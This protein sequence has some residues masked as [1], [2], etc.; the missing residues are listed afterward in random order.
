MATPI[1]Q[2]EADPSAPRPVLLAPHPQKKVTDAQWEVIKSLYCAGVSSGD[3][4]KDY[5]ITSSTIRK[6]ATVEKWPTPQRIS[7]AIKTG[8]RNTDDPAAAIADLW[9]SRKQ[10]GRESVYQGSKKALERFFAMAPVPQSFQEA[11][12]AHKMME[13]AID[14]SEGKAAPTNVNLAL[15]TSDNFAPRVIDV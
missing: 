1:P 11:A 15:L 5:P 10:E 6:R 7:R 8:Q 14:P 4:A 13:K 3:I 9:E 12:I 2:P